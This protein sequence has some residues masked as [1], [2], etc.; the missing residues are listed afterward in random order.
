MK[1][2]FVAGAVW[3]FGLLFAW[4]DWF[5]LFAGRRTRIVLAWLAIGSM[6]VAFKYAPHDASAVITK[7]AETITDRFLPDTTTTTTP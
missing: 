7:T 1:G 5:D 6:Y 4:G 3:V 2:F